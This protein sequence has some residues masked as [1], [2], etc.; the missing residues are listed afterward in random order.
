[1]FLSDPMEK[2][3]STNCTTESVPSFTPPVQSVIMGRGW[4]GWLELPWL[5]L[6][7][8]IPQE[9]GHCLI[10]I[11]AG[12]RVHKQLRWRRV[13]TTSVAENFRITAQVDSQ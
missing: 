12:G 8:S 2:L 5:E 13:P 7:K 6:D 11:A 1:M 10:C 4:G 3:W 9:K